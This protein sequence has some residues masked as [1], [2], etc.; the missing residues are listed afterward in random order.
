MNV[1]MPR[2]SLDFVIPPSASSE[3]VGFSVTAGSTASTGALGVAVT[4]GLNQR[5]ISRSPHAKK[6]ARKWKGNHMATSS[7]LESTKKPETL[8]PSHH[9]TATS[10][11]RAPAI[12][13]GFHDPASSR[14]FLGMAINIWKKVKKPMKP[15]K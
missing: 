5:K 6:A 3:L 1:M 11:R 2:G 15:K 10:E 14:N 13:R 8:P 4:R 9:R 7:Q 12:A